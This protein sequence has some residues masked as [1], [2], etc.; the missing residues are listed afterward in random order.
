MSKIEVNKLHTFLG[1]NDSIYTLEKIDDTRFVSAGADGMVVLWDL[2]SPDE[3]EVIAKI[4]G[5]VY[6]LAYDVVD[7][8]LFVGQ[9][10]EGIHKVDLNKK[11]EVGSIQLG[12][13]QIFSIRQI[14]ETIWVGLS[15]GE[16]VI[17]SNA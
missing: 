17:L 2:K 11:H 16:I 3:G 15:N 6:A 8:F 14:K 1:H 13:Y 7:G 12:N 4:E 9:N 10:N 5:S